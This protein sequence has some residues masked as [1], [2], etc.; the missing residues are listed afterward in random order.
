[1]YS[2]GE[3]R[4]RDIRVRAGRIAEIEEALVASEGEELVEVGGRLVLPG[5]VDP[6]VH[7]SPWGAEPE[8]QFADDF[9]TGSRAALAGGITSLGN[10]T[11]P[12]EGEKGAVDSLGRDAASVALQAACDVFLHPVIDDPPRGL[13][14]LVE[15]R[16]LG[17]TSL[18]VFMSARS[19]PE[20]R[21]AFV[22]LA[23]QAASL[24][25]VLLVHA[26]N[27]EMNVRARTELVREG[28]E[29]LRHY[30]AS[31][32]VASEV[33]AVAEAI[34]LCSDT[35]VA[36]Y[37]VHLSSSAG[38]DLCRE[39]RARGLPVFVETRPLYLFF[40]QEEYERAGGSRF[41][42]EPPLRSA[43]DVEALWS[44]L[45]DGSIDVIA[46]DH[47]ARL[48]HQKECPGQDVTRCFAGAPNLET[49]LPVLHSE[50]VLGRGLPIERFV[51]LT[52]ATPAR[53]FGLTGR[54]G[55]ICE[56]ADADLVV[57]DPAEERLVDGPYQSRAGHCLFQ[58]RRVTGWPQLVFRRGELVTTARTVQAT[59]GSGVLLG[60]KRNSGAGL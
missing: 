10:M 25:M 54:K 47:S 24:D 52:A 50:G 39:A 41:T 58:G 26:E 27:H 14:E 36:V 40:T 31:G 43:L 17:H 8:A 29:S 15:L 7:L 33:A 53:L 9:E 32:P 55:E 49:M 13:D 12:L 37:I 45:F 1:M 34:S 16:R 28:R 30:A 5:G 6:H 11:F 59:P 4:H 51:S 57:W 23:R 56:G 18:K 35:G 20:R 38:L 44:G 60:R 46:S 3:A 48:P 42:C 22:R 19:Y 21:E 2:G